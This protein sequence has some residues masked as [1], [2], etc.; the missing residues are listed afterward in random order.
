MSAPKK[1]G[2]LS[3]VSTQVTF[4]LFLAFAVVLAVVFYVVDKQGYEKIRLESE[5]LI[6]Q[7][8]NTAVNSIATDIRRAS[9]SALDLQKSA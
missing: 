7:T 1:I 4:V 9:R 5:K 3:Q 8:G 2:F 6:V